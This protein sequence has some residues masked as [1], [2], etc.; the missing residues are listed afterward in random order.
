MSSP[1]QKQSYSLY[2]KLKLLV[3]RKKPLICLSVAI[4]TIFFF[5]FDDG[6]REFFCRF[7]FS[8]ARGIRVH[9]FV[10]VL[11]VDMFFSF[12]YTSNADIISNN[13]QA[14]ELNRKFTSFVNI[15]MI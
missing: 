4:R 15:L 9:V 8:Y 10:Y 12:S 11:M 6:V 13:K 3:N 7:L 5:L 1:K 2:F 14:N